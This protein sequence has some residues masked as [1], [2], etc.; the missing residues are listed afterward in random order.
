ME[1]RSAIQCLFLCTLNNSKTT[2]KNIVLNGVWFCGKAF[3]LLSEASFEH[4]HKI[5]IMK[6]WYNVDASAH[7]IAHFVCEENREDWLHHL[8]EPFK[9][10][11]QILYVKN[12]LYSSN[13]DL[14]FTIIIS[15]L[16]RIPDKW[17]AISA[18]KRRKKKQ[19][20]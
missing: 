10:I 7:E 11:Y 15:L 1:T 19:L 3:K 6:D 9:Q 16:I 8:I 18:K 13:K 2:A 14:L 20:N 5:H 4:Y 12:P 17:K